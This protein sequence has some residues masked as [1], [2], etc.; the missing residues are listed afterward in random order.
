MAH[1]PEIRLGYDASGSIKHRGLHATL[2]ASTGNSEWRIFRYVYDSSGYLIEIKGPFI[3]KWDDR[4][5]IC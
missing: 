5:S 2:N 4:D 1:W 3:G